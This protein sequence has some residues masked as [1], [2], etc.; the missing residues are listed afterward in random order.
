MHKIS[1]TQMSAKLCQL[2]QED[3]ALSLEISVTSQNELKSSTV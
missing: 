2:L 3:K 1:L